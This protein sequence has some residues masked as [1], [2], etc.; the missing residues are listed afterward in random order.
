MNDKTTKKM[1]L[2]G[3]ILIGMVVGLAVGIIARL[4]GLTSNMDISNPLYP[5]TV[6]DQTVTMGLF[7]V[8]GS[9]FIRSLQMLVV[10]L[11]FV[12]LVCGTCNLADPAKLGR[13]GGKTI[14]F[15]LVTTAIAIS[16]A[17]FTAVI[18]EPGSS[19]NFSAKAYEAKEAPTLVTTLINLIPTNPLNAMVTGKM[20]QIIV[21]ALLFGIAIALTPGK[22]SERMVQFFNDLNEII[23]KLVT[24]LMNLAPY[25]VFALIAKLTT[26]LGL[27]VFESLGKYFLV[28][29]GVLLIHGFLVYPTL[30]KFLARVNPITFLKKMRPAQL[31]A[32]STASSNATLPV[33]M[34]V[35]TKRLG[36]A[37][38]TAS[39][40]L[41]LGATINMDGTAIMQGVATVF[42]SQIYH[43]D[44]TM[45][46]YLTVILAATMAS[47]GTAGVPGVGLITLAMVLGQVGL[48]VE[49]IAI[50][51]TVDRLLD[52]VRTAINVTGDS[53]VSCIVGRSEGELD[54]SVF[55][56]PNAGIEFEEVHLQHA[57]D[58]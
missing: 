34:E 47:V 31:F 32:F 49:G 58:S 13:L 53:V 55:N 23:M 6:Y 18:L 1:S 46:Q 8:L 43:I 20:L 19:A 35:V 28:V 44:L 12:S 52:M 56:D 21:F 11:V 27:D 50:I 37:P 51:M 24:L 36:V 16:I 26:Q 5:A 33:T 17:L 3:K 7:Q 42:I 22:S 30:L 54:L 57:K 45:G 41:P 40:T 10:P 9:W 2:S 38:S 14:I 39:F 4:L 29:L 25:G 15:Y 48:P